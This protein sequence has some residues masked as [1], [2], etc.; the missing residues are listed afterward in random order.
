MAA[1][2]PSTV[3]T[4]GIAACTIAAKGYLS[5]A[6]VLAD[7]FRRHHPEVPFFVLLADRPDGCFDPEAESFPI[8]SLEDLAIPGLRGLRF[9]YSQ[10]AFTYALTPHLLRH[11]LDRGF[12]RVVYYKQESLITGAQSPAFEALER[13]AIV[14]TPHLLKP[15]SGEDAAERELEI[16]RAG[17][18]NLGLLGVAESAATRRF[19]DWLQDRL[20]AHCRL[21]V[22]A[23]MHYEQRW[24]DLVPAFFEDVHLLRGAGDN[25]GHWNLRER[26]LELRGD[27]FAAAAGVAAVE[28]DGEPVRLFRFSGFEPERP[29]ALSRHQPLATLAGGGA[30]AA[31][32]RAYGE[33]LEAAGYRETSRWPYAFGTFDN[34]VAIPEVARELYRSLGAAAEQFHDPFE[35]APAHSF[36]RWLNQPAEQTA[37]LTRRASVGRAAAPAVTRL[38]QEVAASRPDVQSAFPDLAG[39][40]RGRFVDWIAR[41]GMAEHGVPAELAPGI[42]GGRR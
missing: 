13:A 26:R 3:P 25:L 27:P 29:W 21:D 32:L 15:V 38:W 8:L 9:H 10:Q 24:I 23:G 40:D 6:R 33:A 16:L 42:R 28:V 41:F 4:S 20:R 14:L 5:Y 31:I 39:A 2:A 36:F 19:L 18:F 1:G 22:A 34:G 12:D 30:A 35:T 37:A 7:S 11:L 17:S